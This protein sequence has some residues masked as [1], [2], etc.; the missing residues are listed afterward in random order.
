[1]IDYTDPIVREGLLMLVILNPFAQMVY[2]ANLIADTATWEFRRIFIYAS[3]LTAVI[4]V[5]FA[6]AGEFLLSHVFQVSLP[7]MQIFGGLVILGVAYTYIVRGPEGLR[8]FR[9]DIT[10][11]AQQVALPI[12][13]GPG[14]I[15]MSIRVGHDFSPPTALAIIAAVLIVNAACVLAY[16]WFYKMARGPIE[17]ALIKY[18]SIAMRLNAL[19]IGAV[20]VQMILSGVTEYLAG[21]S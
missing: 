21:P 18:F 7:A 14:L 13:V 10:E 4:C 6:L 1:M 12:M 15:W 20:S 5:I 19:L 17:V 11:I 3:V 9:G 2:L 16:Q 8:L